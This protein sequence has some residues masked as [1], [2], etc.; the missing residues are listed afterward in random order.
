MLSKDP[1]Q[2]TAAD[3]YAKSDSP[4]MAPMGMCES[5]HYSGLIFV[6]DAGFFGGGGIYVNFSHD[7]IRRSSVFTVCVCVCD[8]PNA[9]VSA[10]GYHYLLSHQAARSISN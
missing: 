5:A 3:Q 10:G 7:I 6:H 2:L 9:D 1:L 8:S 4:I